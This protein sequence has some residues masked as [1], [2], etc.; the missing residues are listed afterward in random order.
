MLLTGAGDL[1]EAGGRAVEADVKVFDGNVEA[2]FNETDTGDR[3]GLNPSLMRPNTR[4]M[5]V[6]CTQT[7]YLGSCA[8]CDRAIHCRQCVGSSAVGTRL[9]L[10]GW[11]TLVTEC[12]EAH[13]LVL[14]SHAQ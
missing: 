3:Y 8:H 12:R 6:L 10:S 7:W 4:Q 14:P 2:L 11:V 5:S 13:Q 9:L 1:T